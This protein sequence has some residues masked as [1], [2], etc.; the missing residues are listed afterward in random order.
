MKLV[1]GRTL[2]ELL[3]ARTDPT[4]DRGRFVAAFE[5]NCQALAFAPSQGIIHRDLKPADVMGGFGEVQVMDWGAGQGARRGPTGIRRR[6]RRGV[7]AMPHGAFTPAGSVLG[8]AAC[9]CAP[10]RPAGRR[11][12]LGQEICLLPDAEPTEHAVEQVVGV[13]RSDHLAEPVEGQPQFRRQHLGRVVEQRG[14][15]GVPQVLDARLD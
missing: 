12:R 9:C 14:V 15:V 4:R 2:D 13:D 1:A 6:P 10:S 11:S 8:T 7:R 3:A 5:H